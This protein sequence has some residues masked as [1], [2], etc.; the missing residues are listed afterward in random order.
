[1]LFLL[2]AAY[3]PLQCLIHPGCCD[4]QSYHY[5]TP[6]RT[7]KSKQFLLLAQSQSTGRRKCTAFSNAPNGLI[8]PTVRRCSLVSA[9]TTTSCRLLQ[10]IFDLL[11]ALDLDRR[12]VK[13]RYRRSFQQRPFPLPAVSGL[14]VTV[15]LAD[16]IQSSQISNIVVG[17]RATSGSIRADDR[18]ADAVT[19]IAEESSG[20]FHKS[21]NTPSHG[22]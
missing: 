15:N 2:I 9:V 22:S 16:W 11:P 20:S 6:G 4:S 19:P 8:G 18:S 17:H 10:V 3:Q 14:R 12:L 5:V 1:M 21:R 13:R 7:A